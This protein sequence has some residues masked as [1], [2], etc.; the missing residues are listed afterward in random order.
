M[1][2]GRHFGGEEIFLKIAKRS[3]V[4]YLVGRKFRQNLPRLRRSKEICVFA[5]LV[6]IRKCKMAAIFGERKFF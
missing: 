4:R 6:K 5:F 1:Q 2:N 3:L